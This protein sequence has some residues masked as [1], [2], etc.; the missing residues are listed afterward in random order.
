MRYFAG[1]G[2]CSVVVVVLQSRRAGPV[3]YAVS[4]DAAAGKPVVQWVG[5]HRQDW[6]HRP[7]PENGR[8]PTYQ[9]AAK[10]KPRG[11]ASLPIP[12][13]C[14]ASLRHLSVTLILVPPTAGVPRYSKIL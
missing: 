7:T 13:P 9:S 14:Q 2:G 8:C 4:R 3:G 12:R 11:P 1:A 6:S 5:V 10:G